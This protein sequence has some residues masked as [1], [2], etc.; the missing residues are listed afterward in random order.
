MD[1]RMFHCNWA[2]CTTHQTEDICPCDDTMDKPTDLD[3]EG[4]ASI[5]W[6]GPGR[7]IPCDMETDRAVFYFNGRGITTRITAQN[8]VSS[9]TKRVA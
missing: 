8:A 3:I 6:L 9:P 4:L 5:C 7:K 2:A 1:D